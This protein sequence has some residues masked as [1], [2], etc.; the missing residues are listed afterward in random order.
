M[1]R[2]LSVCV[3]G[4]CTATAH[5]QSTVTLYGLLDSGVTYTNRLPVAGGGTASVISVHPGAMQGSRFGLR[6]TED[7]GGG[8]K[9]VFAL[10][11]GINV[12]TGTAGQGGLPWGRRSVVGIE[13]AYG[14]VLFGR[15][16]DFLDDMGVM[17]SVVDFGSQV[18]AIHGLDRTG[19]QRS[20]NAIRYN[21]T[22]L[23]GW[24]FSAIYGLGENAGDASAGNSAGVGTHFTSG[25]W[26]VAAGYFQ[27]RL[28]SGGAATSS[29]VGFSS[30]GAV[31]GAAG[32]T[33]N[34][35]DVALRTFTLASTYQWDKAR[36]HASYSV[37]E[38]PLAVAGGARS[39]R[40]LS[41]NRTSVLDV[42]VSY[43]VTPVLH[44]SASVI[45]DKV[46]FVGAASGSL[47]QYNAGV[48]YFLSKRTDIYANWGHQS[49]SN[50][51]TAGLEQAP[52]GTL[53]QTL[54]RVGIRHKF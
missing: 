11:A 18:S 45:H 9:A 54:V 19:T 48:D 38:Q 32:V 24:R 31:P 20:N 21:S 22:T 13:G 4:L 1:N 35:G 47:T 52:G 34:P 49:S 3:A 2:L 37:F 23:G 41:N 10:E 12:D 26:R 53:S 33:G 15:Q 16:A 46:R 27:S 42:G 44:L 36:W 7:L 28:G 51:N 43:A 14:T 50:M 39:I 6:G 8:N 25:N 29:D 5:A 17:T 30:I 40:S